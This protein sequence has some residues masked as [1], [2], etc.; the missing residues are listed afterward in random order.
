[1]SA[2]FNQTNINPTT[3]FF[4]SGSNFPTGI[5]LQGTFLSGN[6]TTLFIQP[7]TEIFLGDGAGLTAKYNIS[8]MVYI[9]PTAGATQFL[10]LQNTGVGVP[11]FVLNNVSTLTFSEAGVAGSNINIT[12]LAST[13]KSVYPA[14]VN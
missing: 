14:C 10:N 1:M 9:N 2:L 12:A 5:N 13:L 4:T 8:S 6:G 11:N 7:N 3:S